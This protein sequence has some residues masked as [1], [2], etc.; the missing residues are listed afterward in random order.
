L[1]EQQIE[2][3]TRIATVQSEIAT[4]DQELT[5]RKE[6]ILAWSARHSDCNSKLGQAL[7]KLKSVVISALINKV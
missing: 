3:N 2:M 7:Q 1:K 4:K 6:A 5:K